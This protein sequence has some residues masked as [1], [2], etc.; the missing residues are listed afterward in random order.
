LIGS[1]SD[2]LC[3][4]KRTIVDLATEAPNATEISERHRHR[5]EVNTAYDGRLD[6]RGP[7]FSGMSPD[8]ICRRS[9]NTTITR[10]SSA[11]NSIPS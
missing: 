1:G 3:C 7:R 11:C 6:Q 10:G 9:S 8:G 2:P 5:Y 4:F